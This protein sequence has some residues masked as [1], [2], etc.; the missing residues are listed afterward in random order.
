[1]PQ[2]IAAIIAVLLVLGL[3]S[4]IGN[5]IN[6]G[7]H[8]TTAWFR[9]PSLLDQ[10]M[11]EGDVRLLAMSLFGALVGAGVYGARELRRLGFNLA[12]VTWACAFVAAALLPMVFA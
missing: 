11:S 2:A 12:M 10:T 7:V 3:S 5:G 9:W 1:M 4:W 6:S 8:A